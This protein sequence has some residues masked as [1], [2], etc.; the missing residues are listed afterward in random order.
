LRSDG[1]Q[2]SRR[3]EEERITAL[4]MMEAGRELRDFDGALAAIL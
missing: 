1:S 2:D 3:T 4:A